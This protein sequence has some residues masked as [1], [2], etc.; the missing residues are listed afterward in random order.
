MTQDNEG[1][2][3]S[4]SEDELLIAGKEFRKLQERS[5][6]SGYREGLG[7]ASE[8]GLQVRLTQILI[9]FD[10]SRPDLILP[11]KRATG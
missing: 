5:L 6:T 9:N 3:E 10:L 7:Q 4:G 11:T 1:G 2:M 8:D